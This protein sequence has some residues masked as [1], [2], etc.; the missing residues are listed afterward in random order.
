MKGVVNYG[1]AFKVD[2]QRDGEPVEVIVF[3]Q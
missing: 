1:E 2:V 3:K